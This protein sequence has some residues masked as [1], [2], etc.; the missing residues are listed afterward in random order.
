MLI[1]CSD[2]ANAQ[3]TPEASWLEG[4]W[5]VRLIIRGGKDLDTFV[6]NGYNYVAEAKRIVRDDP[7]TGHV[8]TNFTNNANSS[9]FLLRDNPNIPGLTNQLNQRFFPTIQ[10]EQIILDVIQAFKNTVYSSAFIK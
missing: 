7:T 2:I 8:I 6:S 5:G 10:N 9:L 4:S 1:V 3:Q